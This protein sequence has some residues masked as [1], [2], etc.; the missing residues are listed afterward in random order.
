MD[1]INVKTVLLDKNQ[2]E[3][4]LRGFSHGKDVKISTISDFVDFLKSSAEIIDINSIDIIGENSPG[5]LIGSNI[6]GYY[7]E[8]DTKTVVFS[9]LIDPETTDPDRFCF[10]G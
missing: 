5:A 1:R 2:K 3:L 4:F 7:L 9:W 10:E 8:K 6:N